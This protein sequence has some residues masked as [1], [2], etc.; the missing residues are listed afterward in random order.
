MKRTLTQAEKA[1]DTNQLHEA[2]ITAGISPTYAGATATGSEFEFA[3]GVTAPAVEAVI[4]AYALA[5]KPP[6]PSLLTLWNNYRTAVNNATTVA[7]LKAAL[8]NDLGPLLKA[9]AKGHRGDMGN[10]G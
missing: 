3:E 6:P 7:Q 8:V 10:G 1:H 9:I 4:T 5:P 2:F